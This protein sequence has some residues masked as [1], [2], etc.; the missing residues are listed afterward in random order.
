M[1]ATAQA[2]RAALAHISKTT[3]IEHILVA[4]SKVT[5]VHS[6]SSR[7]ASSPGL[8]FVIWVQ[9]DFLS[10]TLEFLGVAEGLQSA[11][12]KRIRQITPERT[13]PKIA[14]AIR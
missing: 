7:A 10:R 5:D 4:G 6:W 13:H 12:C 9:I 8:M 2:T 14:N 1:N 3:K 11:T